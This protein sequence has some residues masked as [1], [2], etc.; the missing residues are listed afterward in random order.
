[1]GKV[2]QVGHL[3][4]AATSGGDKARGLGGSR[5]HRAAVATDLRRETRETPGTRRHLGP[6]RGQEPRQI[7]EPPLEPAP[8]KPTV[9]HTHGSPEATDGIQR[10]YCGSVQA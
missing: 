7:V 4:A 9:R 10:N 8:N 1:M 6:R 3:R 2:S 5:W